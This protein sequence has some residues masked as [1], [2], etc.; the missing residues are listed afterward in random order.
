MASK[1]RGTSVFV[2]RGVDAET[3]MSA[4]SFPLSSVA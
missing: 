2:G 3:S 1:A 4:V